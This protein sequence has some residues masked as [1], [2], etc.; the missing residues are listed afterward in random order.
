MPATRSRRTRVTRKRHP[1]TRA[2]AKRTR[3]KTPAPTDGWLIAEL[4]TLTG[5]TVRTLRTYVARGLLRPIE[6]RGTATRYP[7]RELLRL[8]KLLHLKSETRG[9]P[10][11]AKLERQLHAISDPEL[12]AW[13][14]RQQWS[15]ALAQALAL[16]ATPPSRAVPRNPNTKALDR[17]HPEMWQRISILPDLELMLRSD[18]S[19]AVRDLAERVCADL[20]G[21]GKK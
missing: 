9:K 2:R 19:R 12:E 11:L 18:A 21:P 15:P 13:A 20:L 1:Y 6:F 14:S 8:L 5:V 4:A 17:G 7:R 3:P 16:E 10:L